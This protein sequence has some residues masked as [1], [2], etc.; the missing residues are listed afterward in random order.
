M[1]TYLFCRKD[2]DSPELAQMFFQKVI[3][4][5]SVPDNIVTDR[6]KEFTR[7]F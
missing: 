5:N 1:A 4:K 2:I 7:P 6:G 3:G